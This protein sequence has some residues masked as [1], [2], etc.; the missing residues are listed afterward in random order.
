MNTREELQQAFDDYRNNRL[1]K[2][3]AV[4]DHKTED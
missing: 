2:H 3:K 4:F 1:V